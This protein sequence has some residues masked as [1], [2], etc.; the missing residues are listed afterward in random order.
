MATL[1]ITD[2]ALPERESRRSECTS[3]RSWSDDRWTMLFSHPDDFVQCEF[4]LDRW[5]PIARRAFL[6]SRIRPLALAHSAHASDRGWVSQ[7]ENDS[8]IVLL[9][10]YDARRALIDIGACV[11]HDEITRLQQRFVMFIDSSLQRRKTYTYYPPVELI[12]PI[13]L[14]SRAHALRQSRTGLDLVPGLPPGPARD[15][16]SQA[17]VSSA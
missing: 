1:L 16:A 15:H 11:L 8:R 6:D 9:H 5:L 12:S 3:L 4:E 2:D 10:P 17:R 7:I 14:I 13:D